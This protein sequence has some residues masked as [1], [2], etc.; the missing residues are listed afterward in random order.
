VVKKG[1]PSRKRRGLAPGSD[2]RDR[3]S[4]T[5]GTAEETRRA[6]W[7]RAIACL[8]FGLGFLIAGAVQALDLHALASRGEVTRAVVLEKHG[9]KSASITVSFRTRTGQSVRGETTNFKEPVTVGGSLDVVYDPQDPATFQD[10]RWGTG[11]SS[12]GITWFLM[13]AGV[14]FLVCFVIILRRGTPEWLR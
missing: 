7:A 9:G 2:G 5:R 4:Q 3:L 12:Y 11:V 1:R 6:R 14:A 10:H 13:G 8:G